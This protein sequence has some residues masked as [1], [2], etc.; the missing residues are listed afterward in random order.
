MS[1][2]RHS[3][4]RPI[5]S[6]KSDTTNKANRIEFVTFDPIKCTS[7]IENLIETSQ[8]FIYSLLQR[9]LIKLLA[10]RVVDI[11]TIQETQNI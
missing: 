9:V 3:T 7:L 2:I 4:M 11:S 1:N 10:A 8:I 5:E 6:K